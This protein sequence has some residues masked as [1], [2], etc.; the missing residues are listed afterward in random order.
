MVLVRPV[1][2]VEFRSRRIQFKQYIMKLNEIYHLIIYC[3]NCIRR[4]ENS[5]A[6]RNF[7]C[8]VI[9]RVELIRKDKEN[10]RSAR[11]IAPSGKPALHADD[12]RLVETTCCESVGLINLVTS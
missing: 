12:I 2:Y 7:L 8:L 6:E 4:G 1:L 9:S 5:R 11:K 3:L 10:F